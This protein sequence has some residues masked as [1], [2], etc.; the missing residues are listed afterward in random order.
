MITGGH[1]WSRRKTCLFSARFKLIGILVAGQRDVP[2]FGYYVYLLFQADAS[3]EQKV[4][5]AGALLEQ[6]EGA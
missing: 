2:G 6:P 1:R 4:L 5:A 3:R